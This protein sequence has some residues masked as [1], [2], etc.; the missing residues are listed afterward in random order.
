MKCRM[1]CVVLFALW[2]AAGLSPAGAQERDTVDE[3]ALAAAARTFVELSFAGDYD[4][5][6]DLLSADMLSAYSAT[7]AEQVRES[8]L[9]QRGPL[10]QIGDAWLED[11]VGEHRRF[12][13]PTEFERDTVDLLVVFDGEG[14]VAGYFQLP[15]VPSPDERAADMS[16]RSEPN[17]AVEGHWEGSIDIPDSPLG[18]LVDLQFMDGYWVGFIDIPA[19]AA[20]GLPLS[21]IGVTKMEVDFAIANLPGNPTFRGKLAD[22][23]ISGTFTQGENSYPFPLGREEIE[24]PSRPQEP[25]PPFPYEEEEVSYFNGQIKLAGTLTVPP[26]DGPF[27]AAL[28]ISGS[29]AQ[30]RNEEVFDHK[31]FL[32][33]ADHLTRAG[34][35]VLRVDD[36]GVGGSTG[37]RSAATSEDF[38]EDALAGVTF[39]SQLPE[40]DPKRVGLIGHSEGG[41]IA[42]MAAIRSGGVAFV[43][44]LAGTG[45]P[46][47][48]VI[49]RQTELISR[50]GGFPEEQIAQVLEAHRKLLE[51]IRSGAGDDEVLA[52]LRELVRAQVGPETSEE[53]LEETVDREM[54]NVKHPWFLFFLEH[55]PRP[56]LRKVRVPVL[57]LCG[58][59][60]LQVDPDQN[61]PEITKALEQGGNTDFTAKEMPGLN[62]MFQRAE[63]GSLSEYY[64]IEETMNP[65]ALE[66][67]SGWI[68]ERFGKAAAER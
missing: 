52:G 4:Q 62:H 65:A 31:P 14:K 51:L 57:A 25:Q 47:D 34:I 8:I 60:D 43:V 41:I 3:V 38:A 68:L 50:V 48:E 29:G 13:V 55:D 42:P 45:V 2:L 27:P 54:L 44:L 26:G 35:A 64:D 17:P 10:K 20:E 23:E 46:G 53:T 15:H 32:V 28:L 33:L 39:L 22:G 19:Q 12:R 56:V 1:P 21:G 30:D 58:E 40:I 37:D 63:T 36:R 5:Y 6:R 66:A 16:L 67:I 7:L 49:T 18:V 59:K 24:K 11:V 61:L 9:A